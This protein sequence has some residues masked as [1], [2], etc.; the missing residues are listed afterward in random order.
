MLRKRGFYFCFIASLFFFLLIS[1]SLGVAQGDPAPQLNLAVR[2]ELAPGVVFQK[3]TGKTVLGE[4][5]VVSMV[6]ANLS[7]T[8]VEVRP[9]LAAT[10]GGRERV[11]AMASS[12]GAVA[13]INGSF[14]TTQGGKTSPVGNLVIDGKPQAAEDLLR[15]AFGL[16]ANGQV[17]FGYFPLRLELRGENQSFPVSGFNTSLRE[18]GV[19]VYTP[20]WGET[21]LAPPGRNEV[22]LRQGKVVGVNTDGNTFI[23]PDGLVAVFPASAKE[24]PRLGSPFELVWKYGAGW[25]GVVHAFT[26]GPLLVEGGKP[27]LEA[28]AEGF[29]GNV[30]NPNPR[31]AMGVTPDKKILLVVV[32]GRQPG[33]SVGLTFEELAFLMVKLGAQVAV[34]LDGGGSSQLWVKG[35][36]VNRPSEG[37]PRAVN[38]AILVLSQIKV[39]LNEERLFF[40]V[41][42]LLEKGRVLVPFRKI[43]EALGAEVTWDE[44]KQEVR[45]LRK[46]KEVVLTVGK[47]EAFRDGKLVRLDVPPRLEA[48]RT[49][50]PLRFVGEAFG[51][52]VAWEKE[53][54][55]VKISAD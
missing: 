24:L 10:P 45:A 29:T 4:P 8:Q 54:K 11:E 32:D 5:L 27:V 36:I 34:G 30:F 52:R 49:L 15:A 37:S 40:D 16:K 1:F 46:D 3:F 22:V 17:V 25:E 6:T 48:G 50:V 42:P 55:S 13:A 31:S 35:K 26:A 47:E 23:P 28:G 2:E 19:H 7:E 14:F 53:T 9:V 51:A 18:E 12:L 41:P 33:Y 21:T 38:N 44:E 43:F 39:Y 20:L